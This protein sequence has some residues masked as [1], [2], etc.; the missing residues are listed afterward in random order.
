MTIRYQPT[1]VGLHLLEVTYNNEP[2]PGSP[3]KFH[4]DAINSGFVTA[5]GPGLTHGISGQQSY[6]TIVTKDAGAGMMSPMVSVFHNLH[7]F[8][9][10]KH[11]RNQIM[12][13]NLLRS[14]I[15]FQFHSAVFNVIK[16]QLKKLYINIPLFF[17]PLLSI[18]YS[19][20]ATSF[21]RFVVWNSF[22]VHIKPSNVELHFLLKYPRM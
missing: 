2:I 14:S 10:K 7:W 15:V 1:E 4:V 16:N 12:F 13:L 6:F 8:I 17:I 20:I 3:F 22:S 9:N 19:Y 5:Y 18:F 11:Q 21:Q